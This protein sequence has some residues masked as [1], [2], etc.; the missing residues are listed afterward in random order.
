MPQDPLNLLCIEPRFPGRLGGV[1]DWLV[2]R[3]GYRCHFYC[4][5]AGPRETWPESAGRGLEVVGFNVGGVAREASVSWKR[6]LE[7]S[8]C[9]AFGCWEVLES[10]RP[11]PVDVV[12]GRSDG[13]G[14]SLFAPVHAPRTPVVQFFDYYFHARQHDLADEAGP[15]TPAA[16]YHWRRAANAIDLLDL[17]NGVLPWAPTSWQRDLFPVEYRD[18]FLVL[19]DGVDAPAFAPRAGRPRSIAGRSVPE[20]ARVV[21]FVARGL[22]RLRGFDRFL[23]L[24]NVLIRERSDVVAMAVGSM[25]V[26]RTLDVAFHGR[27]YRALAMA[28]DPPSDPDRLWFVGD[29]S[30]GEV[31]AIL[32]R[33]DLHIYP[34]RTYPVSRSLFGAMAAGRVVLASDDPPVRE[35]IRPGVDGLLAAPG[36]LDDWVRLARAVLEDPPA[37]APLGSSAAGVVRERYDRDA[38]LPRLAERLN[39]LVGLG[40]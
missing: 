15:E 25:T 26:D 39:Q 10:R 36:D 12:L 28:A 27:D 7:R 18:D 22:D 17:E 11:R 16:Y 8:L 33:S 2:R 19:H 9:Y 30:P 6:A 14:S 31:A 5:Q 21:T 35:V 3:R 23:K 20:G 1:A 34:S 38:T 4:S 32:A 24:A 37:H 40:G 29:V 13:L